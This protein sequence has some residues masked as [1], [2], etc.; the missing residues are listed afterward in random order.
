[1]MRL[2]DSCVIMF[3]ATNGMLVDF[4]VVDFLGCCCGRGFR[5]GYCLCTNLVAGIGGTFTGMLFLVRII[6]V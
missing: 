5:W 4:G 6:L 2:T 3:G 1:M